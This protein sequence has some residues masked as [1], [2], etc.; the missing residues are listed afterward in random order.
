MFIV[1]FIQVEFIQVVDVKNKHV[2][3]ATI[4]N[5]VKYMHDLVFYVCITLT[6]RIIKWL[7]G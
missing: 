7:S 1:L 3:L 4:K 2:S 5:Q 6:M